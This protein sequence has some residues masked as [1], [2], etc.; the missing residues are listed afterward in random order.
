MEIENINYK[1]MRRNLTVLF[2]LLTISFAFG[3]GKYG[4]Y[5]NSKKLA[6]AYKTVKDA[7]KDDYYQQFYWLVTA[8]QLKTYPH[9]KDIKPIVLYEFVKYVNPQNPTKKLD[10]RGKELRATAELSLNQYF[11]NKKFENNSVLMYNLETY[12]DPSKGQ[13]YTKVD[14]EKIKELVPKELFAFNSFNRN[15]G[16]EKTYYL[17]IDKKKDDLNIVDIIPS[18][19]DDKAFYTRLKQYLPSYKFS[20]YVPSVKKGNKSDKTDLEYYYIMPFEQNTDNIE[21]KTKDFK[22]FTLSQ[23][24]KAGDEWKGVEKPRK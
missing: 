15:M 11:K 3:Q 14:P 10:S 4:K 1:K 22:N 21:Y 13:Y 20:K 24:R 17:W 23:Y 18:E 7:D 19:K 2:A 8:E 6:L 5:L 16:E 12:V 9:L